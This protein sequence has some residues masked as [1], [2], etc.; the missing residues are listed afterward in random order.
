MLTKIASAF[1]GHLVNIINVCQT[2][3]A[4]SHIDVRVRDAFRKT[5]ADAVTTRK[6]IDT[7][8]NANVFNIRFNT[9]DEWHLIQR[10]DNF[11]L[12]YDVCHGWK[13]RNAAGIYIGKPI[14]KDTIVECTQI[15]LEQF[16]AANARLNSKD[17]QDFAVFIDYQTLNDHDDIDSL[18]FFCGV[19]GIAEYIRMAA[20]QSKR[21][22]FLAATIND[23]EAVGS[24]IY[25]THGS[26]KEYENGDINTDEIIREGIDGARADLLE[27]AAIRG[28]DSK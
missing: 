18:T 27:I 9:L 8:A 23:E 4:S 19:Y 16:A 14:F 3:A 24:P 5:A 13:N 10:V 26:L 6:I 2:N 7:L 28:G 20:R 1:D 17:F 22:G 21:N 15:V 12:P 25:F 11:S